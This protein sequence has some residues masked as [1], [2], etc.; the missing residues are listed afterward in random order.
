MLQLSTEIIILIFYVQKIEHYM[1]REEKKRTFRIKFVTTMLTALS[2]LIYVF[3][4]S[5]PLHNIL[6]ILFLGFHT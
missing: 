5:L 4:G 1:N 6:F 2:G 3:G